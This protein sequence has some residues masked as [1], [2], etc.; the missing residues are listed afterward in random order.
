MLLSYSQI[1]KASALYIY[2]YIYILAFST[3]TWTNMLIE[4]EE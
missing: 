2:I 1:V 3:S 4:I